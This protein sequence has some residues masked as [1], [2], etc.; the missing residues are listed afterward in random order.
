[1][2]LAMK[3]SE[4]LMLSVSEVICSIKLC[5]EMGWKFPLHNLGSVGIFGLYRSWMLMTLSLSL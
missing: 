4:S 5:R 3:L 1:M 2:Y